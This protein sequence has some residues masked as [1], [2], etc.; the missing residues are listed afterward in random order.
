MNHSSLIQVENQSQQNSEDNVN[1]NVATFAAKY[2]SKRGKYLGTFAHDPVS[3]KGASTF[4]NLVCL[5]LE[6]S[7]TVIFVIISFEIHL[8]IFL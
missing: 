8:T 4:L 7:K 2:Q 6:F 1:V 5:D 3:E